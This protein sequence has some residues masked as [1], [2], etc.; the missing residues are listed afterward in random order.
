[1]GDD[2]DGKG[3]YNY[4]GW[5]VDLSANGKTVAIAG[6]YYINSD[7]KN[8]GRVRVFTF[9]KQKK[10]WVQVGK[11]LTSAIEEEEF[12]VAVSI[13]ANGKKIAI[14][15]GCVYYCENAAAVND[16]VEIYSLVDGTTWEKVGDS[17]YAGA[18]R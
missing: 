8:V 9:K 11:D 4:D 12:G 6:P 5:T 14:S 2:I 7:E 13:S 3:R 18:T 16:R 1:M 15:A 10:E 17:I